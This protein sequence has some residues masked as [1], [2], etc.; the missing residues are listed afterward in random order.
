VRL[1]SLRV[2]QLGYGGVTGWVAQ[3]GE[4]FN[5][6][7]CTPDDVSTPKRLDISCMLLNKDLV[8][9]HTLPGCTRTW[10]RQRQGGPDSSG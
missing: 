7:E 6:G 3:F 8:D 9:A 4:V 1:Q 10:P 5:S 2:V